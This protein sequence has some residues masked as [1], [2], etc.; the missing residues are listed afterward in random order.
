M[1]VI[2]LEETSSGGLDFEHPGAMLDLIFG[3]DVWIVPGAGLP[4][5]P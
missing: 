3:V 5:L 2:H 1:R 4:H